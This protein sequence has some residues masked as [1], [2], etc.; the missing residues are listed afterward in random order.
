LAYVCQMVTKAGGSWTSMKRLPSQ[1]VPF[2]LFYSW[3]LCTRP[4]VYTQCSQHF[5]KEIY[6][7][8]STDFQLFV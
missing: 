5:L 7:T 8:A 6:K 2:L 4:D 3:T 1:L